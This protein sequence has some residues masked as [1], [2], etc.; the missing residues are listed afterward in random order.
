MTTMRL[1]LLAAAATLCYGLATAA[2]PA[3]MPTQRPPSLWS[4]L[5]GKTQSLPIARPLS[6]QRPAS[7]SVRRG[8]S[9]VE[10]A[11]YEEPALIATPPA[12]TAKAPLPLTSWFHRSRRP[13][14]TVSKYMAEERP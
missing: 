13:S 5:F 3:R 4:K 11:N 9:G 10:R 12:R 7:G 8:S 2:E 1:A 6:R 14:R